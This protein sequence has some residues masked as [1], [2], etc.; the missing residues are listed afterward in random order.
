MLT[1]P[2]NDLTGG[3]M[4]SEALSYSNVIVVWGGKVG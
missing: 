2:L 4:V 1:N 3:G